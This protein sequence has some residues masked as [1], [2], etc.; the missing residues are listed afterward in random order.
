MLKRIK[1]K[2]GYKK[3]RNGYIVKLMILGENNEDLY[4]KRDSKL[5]IK[6]RCSKAKVLDIFHCITNERINEIPSIYRNNFIY[7]INEIVREPNYNKEKH[8][9]CGEGIH[10]FKTKKQ[11]KYWEL[12]YWELHLEN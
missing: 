7:K 11:A 10:Y 4:N 3:A 5:Y 2:I 1:R 6:Y 9:I 12:Q 8:I